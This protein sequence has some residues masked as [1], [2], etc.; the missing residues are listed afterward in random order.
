MST[1]ALGRKRAEGITDIY[2]DCRCCGR[3]FVPTITGK[4]R[5]L[6]AR[7]EKDGYCSGC[8]KTRGRGAPCTHDFPASSYRCPFTTEENARH[9]DWFL[10][11]IAGTSRK[12]NRTERTP[13]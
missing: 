10:D 13:A 12:L 5:D 6:Y 1:D 4:D 8:Y 3:L 11:T 9:L 2:A 7:H